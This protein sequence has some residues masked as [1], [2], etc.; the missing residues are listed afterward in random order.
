MPTH[1]LIVYD[2]NL[3]NKG[4]GYNKGDGVFIAPVTWVYVFHFSMYVTEGPEMPWTSL[5]L[6]GNGIDIG[7]TFEESKS[8]G[9]G[10]YHCS[11]TLV[12]SDVDV[13]DHI[14]SEAKIKCTA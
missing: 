7:S 6:T 12:V 8:S 13:G 3:T 14:F 9:S 10:G 5:E 4:N 11:S 2:L 1:H